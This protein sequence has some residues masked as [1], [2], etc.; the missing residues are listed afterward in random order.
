MTIAG[1]LKSSFTAL[2]IFFFTKG[3]VYKTTLTIFAVAICNALNFVFFDIGMMGKIRRPIND[4]II[5]PK[6]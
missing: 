6:P 1:F 2:I 4:K 3:L 5:P